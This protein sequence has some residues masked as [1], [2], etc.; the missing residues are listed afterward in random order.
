MMNYS[1]AKRYREMADK[2]AKHGFRLAPCRLLYSSVLAMEYVPEPEVKLEYH[3]ISQINRLTG[4][5]DLH[6]TNVWA[7]AN[8]IPTLI[9]Y[10]A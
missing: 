9:D 5:N 4:V 2:V 10:A 1:E 3:V 8:G 6:S 7:D